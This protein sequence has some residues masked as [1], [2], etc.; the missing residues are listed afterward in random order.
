MEEKSF[1]DLLNEG[2]DE[3][4]LTPEQAKIREQY[5]KLLEEENI[6]QQ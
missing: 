5:R 4:I 6:P 1:D 2:R 3:K